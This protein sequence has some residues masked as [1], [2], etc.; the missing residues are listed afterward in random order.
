MIEGYIGRPGS[1]KT[2]TLTERALRERAKGREVFA[3]YAID[4]CWTFTADQLLDLPPGLIILDEA[5]LWFPARQALR[6]PPSWLAMLSQTRKNGWDLFWAAQHETRVDRVVR[7]VTSWMWLCSAW[8]KYN[9]HPV[10]FKAE[11]YEPE[12]FRKPKSRMTTTYRT[13]SQ[14]TAAGYDTLQRLEVAKH[15]QK[16]DDAYAPASKA[17]YADRLAVAGARTPRRRSS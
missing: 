3:N 8:F 16:E 4:G 13:F 1:G 7:D 17:D 6:L 2:Y 11:S 5:H 14:K 15:A 12:F 10:L 9:G